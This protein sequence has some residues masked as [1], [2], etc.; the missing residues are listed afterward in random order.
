MSRDSKN[1]SQ[2]RVLIELRPSRISGIG[3]FAVRNIRKGQKVAD[4]LYAEDF[5]TLIPW[6]RFKRF[7]AS[8]RRKIDDFCIG[9]PKGFVP[10]DNLDFNKLSIEWY[11][12]HSCEGNVGFNLNGDFIAIEKIAKGTELTYDYGIAE[13]N[14]RFRMR[15][16][17]GSKT[18][19]RIITGNDWKQEKLRRDKGSYML[20]ELRRL[21][22]SG[23]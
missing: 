22:A 11:F 3:V 6:K 16:K 7:D 23:D 8:V 12:D 5:E 9:T 13:S 2:P 10:P 20:P 14:P 21:A 17:C 4:G 18:C 1:K 15:C 19:R